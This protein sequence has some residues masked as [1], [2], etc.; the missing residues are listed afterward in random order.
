M[1]TY[2]CI[3][4]Y[5]YIY[6]YIYIYIYTYIYVYVYICKYIHTYIARPSASH[7]K[8]Y[9]VT[10]FKT[11][12]HTATH[13]SVPSLQA[14]DPLQHTATH[15]NTQQHTATHSNT[16]QHTATHSNTQLRTM[17]HCNILQR[18]ATHGNT[19]LNVRRVPGARPTPRRFGAQ[20][21]HR[22]QNTRVPR[23]L[24]RLTV[25]RTDEI[26]QKFNSLII[27]HS[28]CSNELTFEKSYLAGFIASVSAPLLG[29]PFTRVV[30][31][32]AL[33]APFWPSSCRMIIFCTSGLAQIPVLADGCF[34]V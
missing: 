4:I 27:L 5:I 6:M 16:Q 20:K 30:V 12:R 25:G 24:Q 26:S 1:Y 18:F 19:N 33:A 7:S 32:L 31:A 11:L 2:I 10:H 9:T 13:H 34:E 28:K 21:T 22:C 15:S 14:L 3:Y 23:N 17:T 8:P 29:L